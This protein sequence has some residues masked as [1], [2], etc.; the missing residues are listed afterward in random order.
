MRPAYSILV[1]F[2]LPI[3]AV[4]EI[5]SGVDEVVRVLTYLIFATGIGSG[6]QD[7]VQKPGNSLIVRTNIRRNNFKNRSNDWLRVDKCVI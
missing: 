2:G 4:S 5:S 3:K 7:T 6:G 1:R